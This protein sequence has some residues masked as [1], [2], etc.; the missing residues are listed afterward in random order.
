MIPPIHFSLEVANGMPKAERQKL[1]V[2]ADDRLVN[3]LQKHFSFI[4]PQAS[5]P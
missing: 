1:I 5:L 2:T 4:V 3:N